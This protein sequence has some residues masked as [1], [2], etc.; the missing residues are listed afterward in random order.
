MKTLRLCTLLMLLYA[1]ASGQSN[2][3]YSYPV[4]PGTPA[5]N[6]LPSTEARVQA[7]QIPADVLKNLSTEA[8]GIT[9]LNYPFMLDVFATQDLQAGFNGL[10]KS[11][12]GF[13]ELLARKDAGTALLGIYSKMNPNSLNKNWAPTEKGNFT[14]RFIYVELLLAQNAV[15]ATLDASNTQLLRKEALKKYEDKQLWAESTG[16]ISL[17]TSAWILGKLLQKD[18]VQK[19]N[20]TALTRFLNTGTFSNPALLNEIY[21]S[22]KQ[23]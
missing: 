19:T 2:T 16:G 7:S 3:P 23:L 1:A 8:L 17:N 11:F 13:R 9:C 12:N 4:K 15:I 21:T 22:S 5:W 6:N 14:L 20:D 10:Q 18:N